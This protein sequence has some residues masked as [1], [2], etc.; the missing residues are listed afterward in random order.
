MSDAQF[1]AL[2]L[3][4]LLSENFILV[5]CVGIGTHGEAFSTPKEGARTGLTLTVVMVVTALISRPIDDI[6][7]SIGFTYLRVI[8]FALLVYAVIILLRKMLAACLPVLSARVD[9][10]L[11]QTLTN[12]AVLFCI[13]TAA[14]RGY[15]ITQTFIYAFFGGIGA[16]IVMV[17]FAG[18]REEVSFHHCPKAF[19]GAPILF[20]T[21]GL[22]ALAVVGFYGLHFT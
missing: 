6:L 9:K 3:S 12:A 15:T 19:R 7:Q 2:V 11:S 22:M 4:A 18:L 16:T 20:I 8:I 17:S 14:Q 10:C 21:M 13:L 5:T 1:F